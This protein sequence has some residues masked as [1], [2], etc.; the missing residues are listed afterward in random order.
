ML[1]ILQKSFRMQ[2]HHMRGIIAPL[3]LGMITLFIGVLPNAALAREA[4]QEVA[5]CNDP[6]HRHAV[7]RPLTESIPIRKSAKIRVR[8][9][10]M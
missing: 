8:R 10:L 9:I 6:K 2:K 7:V 5:N 4:E 3:S 1:F